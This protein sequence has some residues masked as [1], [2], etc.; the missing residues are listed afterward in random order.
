FH[1]EECTSTNDAVVSYIS[2]QPL[3]VALFTFCQTQGRGQYGNTWASPRNQNLAY[4]IALPLDKIHASDV[5]FN[6]HTA[7]IVKDFIAKMTHI[8]T[9][10]KWPNDIIL[11]G[12]K[13]SG[14]LIEKRKI[15]ERDYYIVGIGINILQEDFK[16]LPKAGSLFTQTG[17]SFD[18]NDFT[19][20]FHQ[21]ISDKL[22]LQNINENEILEQFNQ[23]LFR[24]DQISVFEIKGMR[25]NGIIRNTDTDG[26]LWIELENDGLQRFYHKEVEL[27]Y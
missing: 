1:I 23:N 24:K 9:N 27:L 10:I 12:K 8:D 26:F 14:M 4:S 2:Q 6:F 18:L 20:Q 7:I 13:I 15:A 25:Q 3:G 5:S 16:H 19:Q 11:K 22:V 17:K 21:E